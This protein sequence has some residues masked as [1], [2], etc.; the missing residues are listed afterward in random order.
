MCPKGTYAA[1]YQQRVEA[2]QGSDGM[3]D[4]DTGLNS[5]R[6]KCRAWD[7][8]AEVDAMSDAGYG[9]TWHPA[10]ECNNGVISGM[11]VY[12]EPY[13]GT[14]DDEDDSGADKVVAACTSGETIEAPGGAPWGNPRGM[15]TRPVGT[16]VCGIQDKTESKQ[17]SD[18]DDTAMNG[19]ALAC[20][21]Y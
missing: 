8:G 15:V 1:S 21:V 17:G 11:E 10:E 4:D 2:Y 3:D 6:L 7:G 14:G 19:V 20:C 18:I 16:A 9:G 13:Q 12:F 5:I